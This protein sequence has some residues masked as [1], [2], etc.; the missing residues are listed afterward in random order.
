[1]QMELLL[2]ENTGFNSD[3]ESCNLYLGRTLLL[4]LKLF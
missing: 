1:M 2:T 3:K 4:N